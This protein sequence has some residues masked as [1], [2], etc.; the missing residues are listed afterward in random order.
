MATQPAAEIDDK[1]RYETLKRELA[2]TLPKKGSPTKIWCVPSA[3]KGNILPETIA[4]HGGNIIHGFDN[5]LKNQTTGRKRYEVADQDRVFSNSS[6]T[7]QKSLDLLGEVSDNEDSGKLSAGGVTTVTVPPA[8][9]TQTSQAHANK[10]I[11]DR[12]YSRKKRAQNRNRSAGTVSDDDSV[13]VATSTG[14]PRKR[15]RLADD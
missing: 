3:S 7:I 10:L 9:Q 6:L 11:R 5:F 12:E 14:R 13:S 8:T 15:P 4:Q 2:L 1:T